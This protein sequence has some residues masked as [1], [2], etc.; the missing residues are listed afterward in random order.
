MNL[1]TQCGRRDA[2]LHAQVVD[3]SPSEGLRQKGEAAKNLGAASEVVDVGGI[4]SK[5]PFQEIHPQAVADWQRERRRRR[6]MA[7]W[8]WWSGDFLSRKATKRSSKWEACSLFTF[9]LKCYWEESDP[10]AGELRHHWEG[11]TLGVF[12]FLLLW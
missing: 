1:R 5:D 11:R 9:G 10:E 6:R 8:T 3:Y 2:H 7:V 12:V 4:D